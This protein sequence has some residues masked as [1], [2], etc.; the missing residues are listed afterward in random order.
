MLFSYSLLPGNQ[1]DY[2]C[3][4]KRNNHCTHG[5]CLQ[6]PYSVSPASIAVF[7]FRTAHAAD[8]GKGRVPGI[9]VNPPVRF[10]FLGIKTPVINAERHFQKFTQS[11]RKGLSLLL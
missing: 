3:D 11:S 9:L 5:T 6:V 7:N 1:C 10:V 2:E 4:R 8:I